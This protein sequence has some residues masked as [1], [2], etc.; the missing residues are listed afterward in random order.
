MSVPTSAKYTTTAARIHRQSH[1][2]YFVCC[3]LPRRRHV[4]LEPQHRDSPFTNSP[5]PVPESGCDPGTSPCTEPEWSEFCKGVNATSLFL[6][7]NTPS[8]LAAIIVAFSFSSSQ[9]RL[10]SSR[11]LVSP[12]A[13]VFQAKRYWAGRPPLPPATAPPVHNK[14]TLPLGSGYEPYAL[15][16]HRLETMTSLLR[17]SSSVAPH[18]TFLLNSHNRA[19]AYCNSL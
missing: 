15:P 5:S 19:T 7:F 16:W 13:S 6:I 11:F 17:N 8:D 2:V 10:F 14:A 9:H 12:S 3:S 1:I 18:L 4:E